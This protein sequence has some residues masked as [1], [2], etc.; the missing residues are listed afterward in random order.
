MQLSMVVA[1]AIDDFSAAR[2][3]DLALRFAAAAGAPAADVSVSVAPGSVQLL[4]TVRSA[5]AEQ[6][7]RIAASL[8]QALI[9]AETASALLQ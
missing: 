7:D 4:F 8:R 3:S 6:A 2:R 1:G 5:T 9:D